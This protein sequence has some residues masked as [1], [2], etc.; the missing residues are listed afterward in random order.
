MLR[1]LAPLALVALASCGEN[2]NRVSFQGTFYDADLSRIDGARDRFTVSVR[3]VSAGLDGAREAGRYEAV[4]HCIANYGNSDIT[5]AP[6]P[7]SPQT[8]LPISENTVQF[9]GT[10]RQ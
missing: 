9:R 7:D 5:W 8:A 2:P 4:K 1:Y 10:C 6:G 3:P